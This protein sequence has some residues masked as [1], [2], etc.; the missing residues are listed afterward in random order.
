MVGLSGE[1][2]AHIVLRVDATSG[3]SATTTTTKTRR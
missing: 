1:I 3:I 2:V